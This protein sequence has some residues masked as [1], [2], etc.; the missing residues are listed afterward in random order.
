M[1][2]NT[3]GIPYQTDT[4]GQDEVSELFIP[5]HSVNETEMFLTSHKQDF[6]T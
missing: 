1:Q 4:K 3:D 5:V 2:R 6:R